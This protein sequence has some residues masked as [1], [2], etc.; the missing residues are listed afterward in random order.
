MGRQKEGY[1]YFPHL[2]FI[3]TPTP[4]TISSPITTALQKSL[5]FLKTNN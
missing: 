4:I 5:P 3:K 1:P 2:P